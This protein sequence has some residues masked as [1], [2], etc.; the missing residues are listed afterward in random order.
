MFQ[1]FRLIEGVCLSSSHIIFY[2]IVQ[3]VH[4][5]FYIIRDRFSAKLLKIKQAGIFPY[6]SITALTAQFTL[7]FGK[8]FW[9]HIRFYFIPYF[10]KF[11]D[12]L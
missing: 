12:L 3:I 9:I 2:Q 10:L 11:A 6:L 5:T 1:N 4:R 7:N 8:P